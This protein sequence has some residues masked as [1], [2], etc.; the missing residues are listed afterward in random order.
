MALGRARAAP[1]PSGRAHRGCG[2]RRARGAPAAAG[3][4]GPPAWV[5]TREITVG[6]QAI[7]A[8]GAPGVAF[9][10]GGSQVVAKARPVPHAET[11]AEDAQ[12][13]AATRRL[14]PAARAAPERMATA[15]PD[16]LSDAGAG[17]PALR[18]P[19]IGV[20]V[21][22][23]AVKAGRWRQRARQKVSRTAAE[24]T[25]VENHVDPS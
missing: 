25:A 1:P 10:A 22:L 14:A 12:T 9:G 19:V 6:I 3:A 13:R 5:E 4:C 20:A 16:P 17:A 24:T 7:G 18:A 8:E 2:G 23:Q 21:A 11:V 15:S